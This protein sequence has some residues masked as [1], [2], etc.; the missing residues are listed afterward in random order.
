MLCLSLS[1]SRCFLCTLIREM[2]RGAMSDYSAFDSP[3]PLIA[4]P[5]FTRFPAIIFP[6]AVF[7][8][9][10][11][12]FTVAIFSNGRDQF[13]KQGEQWPSLI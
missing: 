8:R 12:G 9:N 5:E 3:L 13:F 7:F 11:E 2:K 4:N 6:F 10:R 1:D